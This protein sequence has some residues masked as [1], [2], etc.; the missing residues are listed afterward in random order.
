MIPLS[1]WKRCRHLTPSFR[2]PLLLA[3]L[4][5]LAGLFQV[6]A[7]VIYT[8]VSGQYSFGTGNLPGS[9]VLTLDLPGVNDLAIIDFTYTS[10]NYYQLTILNPGTAA[11]PAYIWSGL[12]WASSLTFNETWDDLP[13]GHTETTNGAN[14]TRMEQT[15]NTEY[16]LRSDPTYLPFRFTDS[17]DSSTKYGYIALTTNKSGTGPTAQLNLD[18]SGYAYDN[19]GAMIAMGA[20]PEPSPAL[21]VMVGILGIAAALRWRHS[22]GVPTA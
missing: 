1:I 17:T 16:G 9:I 18:V 15:G 5:S 2:A 7:A 13:V 22:K 19:S 4:L 3:A 8:N 10:S 12:Y 20:I 11:I 6:P 21:S 14:I